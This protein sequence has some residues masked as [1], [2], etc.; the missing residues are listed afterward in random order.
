[1][2]LRVLL[3]FA[4]A[5]CVATADVTISEDT[6]LPADADW[7]DQGTLVVNAG[8]TLNLAG[9]TLYVAGLAGNGTING[10][11]APTYKFFRFK[12][13]D[14]RGTFLQISELKLFNGETD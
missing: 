7:R 5:A 10:A 9:H 4:A 11:G 13:E 8:A 3:P 2:K 1:M 14:T 12:V 6:T